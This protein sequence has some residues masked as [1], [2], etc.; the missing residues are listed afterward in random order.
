[1]PVCPSCNL[2]TSGPHALFCAR[3]GFALPDGSPRG[4]ETPPT[5]TAEE[6]AVGFDLFATRPW[7]TPAASSPADPRALAVGL[8]A[9]AAA[10][11]LSI[12]LSYGPGSKPAGREVRLPAASGPVRGQEPLSRARPSVNVKRYHAGDYS[13]AYPS[14]WRIRQSERPVTSYRETVVDRADGAAKVTIDYSPGERTEPAAK[15]LQVEAPTSTTRGYRQIAFRPTSIHGR[16]AFVWEFE[17]ADAHPRRVD[18]FVR[19][20][21]GGFA[22]LADGSDLEA[23]TSAARLI[24]GSLS[25]VR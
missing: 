13:F 1:M 22:I 8:A 17:V 18:L 19:A 12:W 5:V 24:A 21:S 25:G 10:V 7:R 6:A 9:L 3:C 11:V 4:A 16:S 15:A 23:A 2:Q 20:N 14:A